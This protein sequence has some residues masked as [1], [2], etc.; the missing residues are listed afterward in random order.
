MKPYMRLATD[1]FLLNDLTTRQY[2]SLQFEVFINKPGEG[3]GDGKG[4]ILGLTDGHYYGNW[5]VGYREPAFRVEPNS[6]LMLMISS[7][8]RD[9]K[10]RQNIIKYNE[11]LSFKLNIASITD[12]THS[13]SSYVSFVL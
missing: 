12:C 11:W 13:V 8:A 9:E 3:D 2:Y 10:T 5:H 7:W 6:R 4:I 1:A